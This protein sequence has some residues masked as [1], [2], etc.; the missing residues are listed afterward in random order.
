[1]RSSIFF[2]YSFT[3]VIVGATPVSQQPQARMV[4]E[5]KCYVSGNHQTP[6]G[7]CYEEYET[8]SGWTGNCDSYPY[9]CTA[10]GNYCSLS[11]VPGGVVMCT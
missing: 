7:I 5:G 6:N 9:R 3:A 2:F 10:N 1:M 4:V 11:T 8:R